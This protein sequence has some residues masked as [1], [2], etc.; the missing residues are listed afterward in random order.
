MTEP[1]GGQSDTPWPTGHR[2][3]DRVRA[4][5]AA[6]H[7]LLTAGHSQRAIARQL[8]M[9]GKT[10]AR[11]TRAATPEVLFTGQWQNRPTKLDDYKPYLHQRWTSGFTNVWA[12]WKEITAQG[13][14]GGYGAVSAYIRPMRTTP[15]PVGTRP[16]SARRVAGW[17]AT[18]PDDLAEQHGPVLTSVLAHCPELDALTRHVRAF[19]DMLVHLKGERLPQWINDIQ[20]DN[21]PKLHNFAAGLQRDLP[22]VIAG[23]TQPWN[24]G[25]VEGQVNRIK[26]LKRQMF[27]RAGFHLLRKRTLLA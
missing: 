13:Y 23:L 22:A 7:E 21:L 3:A 4:T 5:H 14:T 26:M 9:G 25:A 8:S 12:L 1:E 19:A 24:S 17:I 16:P 11:Y 18:H 10:V 2:Y 15:Q 6:V 27:G 20:A